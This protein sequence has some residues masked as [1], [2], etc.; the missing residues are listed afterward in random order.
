MFKKRSGFFDSEEGK[1]IRLKLQYMTRD[2]A[3]NT[4]SSYTSDSL[5]YPDS[6]MPFVDKHMNYLNSHPEL[7]SQMYIANVRLK[8]RIR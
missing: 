2:K 6:K 5:L 7:D 1:E 4:L 3:F 8:T